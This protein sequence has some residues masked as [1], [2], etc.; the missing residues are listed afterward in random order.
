MRWLARLLGRGPALDPAQD[1]ARA[2]WRALPA[3]DLSRDFALARFVVLD[4]ESSGLDPFRDRLISIG[5]IAVDGGRVDLAQSFEVVLR[6]DTASDHS[7]ILIHGITGTEQ[8]GGVA[9]AEALLRFLAFAR[10]DPLVAYH[11]GFDKAMIGRA[12][13]NVLGVR[14]RQRWLDLTYLAPAACPE[15]AGKG[16]SL[17][18]WL[19]R[20]GITVYQRHNAVADTLATAQLFVAVQAGARRGGLRTCRD[21][22]K[23]EKAEFWQQR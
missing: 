16:R 1:R 8:R 22:F 15:R 23:A 19:G 17:D 3:P 11:A 6:Q 2:A 20:F 4:V 10:K 18:D 21:L 9:P 13:R 14:L 12:L 5:A 7:N